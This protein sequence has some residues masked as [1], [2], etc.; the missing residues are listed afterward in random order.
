MVSVWSASPG[1]ILVCQNEFGNIVDPYAVAV[2][3]ISSST[4]V[5]HVPRAISAVYHF[6]L[7]RCGSSI[8]CQVTGSRQYSS[9]LPQGGL[10]IPCTLTFSGAEKDINI[11]LL[12]KAPLMVDTTVEPPAKRIKLEPTDSEK[13]NTDKENYLV[14]GRLWFFD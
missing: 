4:A 3:V 2:V 14:E 8:Q 10:E 6:F 12:S 13:G 5:G 1:D 11:K 9:D 7:R